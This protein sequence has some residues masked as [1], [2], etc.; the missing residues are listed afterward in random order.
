MNFSKKECL[1]FLY[2]VKRSSLDLK[3]DDISESSGNKKAYKDDIAYNMMRMWQGAFGV[4]VEDCMVSPAYVVLAPEDKVC[5]NF[6]GYLFKLPKYLLLL[7][8]HSQGLTQDRLRFYYKDFAQISLLISTFLEQQKIADCISSVDDLITAQTQK[9]GVVG[10]A[11]DGVVM[12]GILF[13]I[14]NCALF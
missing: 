1:F 10:A 2:L 14:L 6:F 13:D 11:L 7:T 8:S 3:F 4:S 5:S 9:L 12:I